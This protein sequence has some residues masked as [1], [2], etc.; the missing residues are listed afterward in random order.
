MNRKILFS[1]FD[2]TLFINGKVSDED[3]AAIR[4]WRAAG[5]LF[6]M[7]SGRHLT[8]LKE[9]LER[10]QVEWDFMLCLNGAEAFDHEDNRL[11]EVPI[12]IELLP[13]LFHTITLGNG[14][15]N[16]CYGARGERIRTENCTDYN[17]DHVHHSE[18]YLSTF[19]RFTQ[20]CSASRDKSTA[21]ALEIKDRILARFGDH[22]S[23]E[24]NGWSIDINAKGVSKASGIARLIDIIDIDADQVYAVGDNYND[25]SM[26][27][28]YHGCAV[29]N[30]PEA[31][32]RQTGTTAKSVA[33]L[34]DRLLAENTAAVHYGKLVRDRIPEIIRREGFTPS[35]RSLGDDEYLAELYRK[36]REETEEYLADENPEE[37]ADI[38][39]VLDA[40]CAFKGFSAEDIQHIKKLKREKRGGFEQKLYLINK[41]PMKGE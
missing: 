35:V 34:I 8:P 23:A 41:R 25:L 18:D 37:I 24:V 36:L 16:V 26:L 38:L 40:I 17:H 13:E 2:G 4:R 1:D 33:E 21:G 28:A 22:V 11:F 6:A 29:A 19:S 31:V 14:W 39:E 3:R 15:A 12:N 32:R 5:N 30:A 20:I 27:T 9:H 7:A 10:E